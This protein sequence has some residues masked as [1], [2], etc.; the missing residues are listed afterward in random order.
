MNKIKIID[1]FNLIANKEEIP[2]RIRF[3]GI[4]FNWINNHYMSEDNKINLTIDIMKD[5]N[6]E[7]EIIEEQQ[8][9]DIQSIEE[10]EVSMNGNA[11]I[12]D[13]RTYTINQLVQAVKQL[14][15]QIKEKEG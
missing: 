10:I 6:T 5:L 15:K 8:D 1:L 12:I 7:I 3:K 2:K 13:N 14:D 11:K 4:I 9:I